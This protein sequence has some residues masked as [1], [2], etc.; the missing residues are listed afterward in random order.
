MLR[1]RQHRPAGRHVEREAWR[2]V[3]QQRWGAGEGTAGEIVVLL[4]LGCRLLLRGAMI[5]TALSLGRHRLY[6]VMA[7]R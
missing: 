3:Q 1:R 2:L 5:G 6:P 7:A 4:R